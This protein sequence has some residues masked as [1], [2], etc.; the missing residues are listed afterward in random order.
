MA[1]MEIG[2]PATLTLGNGETASLRILATNP[3]ILVE[4]LCDGEIY[5]LTP[6]ACFAESDTVLEG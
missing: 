2:E 1:G 6:I 3:E 4:D 5:R